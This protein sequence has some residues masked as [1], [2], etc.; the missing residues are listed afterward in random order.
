MAGFPKIRQIYNALGIIMTLT[1]S[2]RRFESDRRNPAI[3]PFE[4]IAWVY[5][6]VNRWR[7]RE[8]SRAATSRLDANTLRDVGITE[9]QRFIEGNKPFWEA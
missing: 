1:L 7:H 2:Y 5:R 8:I 4:L 9:A 3:Y 6:V